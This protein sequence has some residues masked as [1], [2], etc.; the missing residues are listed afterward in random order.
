ME[1]QSDAFW[2]AVAAIAAAA[3]A[4]ISMVWQRT[5]TLRATRPELLLDGWHVDIEHQTLTIRADVLRNVGAGSASYV[6]CSLADD[7]PARGHPLYPVAGG[8]AIPYLAAGESTKVDFEII[9]AEPVPEDGDVLQGFSIAMWCF[10]ELGRQ[11]ATRMKLLYS[12][13]TVGLAQPIAPRL[14]LTERHVGITGTVHLRVR[15]AWHHVANLS[16]AGRAWLRRRV[17]R[18]HSEESK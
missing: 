6:Y 16:S 11:H 12:T 9:D 10:D 5:A 15:R 3:A 13:V 14:W 7:S 17:P 4:I 2:S 18:L 8:H 1:P